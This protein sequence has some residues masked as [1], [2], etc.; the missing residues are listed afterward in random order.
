MTKKIK[1]KRGLEAAL[2]T[3]Q[4]GEPGFTTDSKKLFVGSDAGNIEI[5]GG[6]GNTEIEALV[7]VTWQELKDKRDAG[8]LAPGAQYRITDYLTTTVQANTRVQD[9]NLILFVTLMMLINLNENA[10]R[11]HGG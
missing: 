9:I 5:G 1:I 6:G 3:L 11:L 4:E 7:E 10:E 2:P 8:E